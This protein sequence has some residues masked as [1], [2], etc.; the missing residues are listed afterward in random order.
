M[1]ELVE[2]SDIDVF[3]SDAAWAICPTYHTV[4]KTSPGAAILGQDM[5]FDILFIAYWKKIG[6]HRQIITDLTPPMKMKAGLIMITKLVRKY[7]YG[8]LVYSAMQ[9]P[10]ISKTPGHLRQSIR[11]EQS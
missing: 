11:M 4:L 9:N 1:A 2:A 5:L 7:F 8:K 3:L 10:G 6:E